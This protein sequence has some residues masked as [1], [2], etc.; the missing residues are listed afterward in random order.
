MNGIHSPSSYDEVFLCLQFL[1]AL[2]IS[3]IFQDSWWLILNNNRCDDDITQRKLTDD[4]IFIYTRNNASLG[5]AA[6]HVLNVSWGN[7]ENGRPL[8][9]STLWATSVLL[10]ICYSSVWNCFIEFIINLFIDAIF[11]L[12]ILWINNN[13]RIQ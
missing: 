4:K 12:E 3:S 11:N 9:Y 10:N 5:P 7:W 6:K 13:W 8:V 2:V 1:L